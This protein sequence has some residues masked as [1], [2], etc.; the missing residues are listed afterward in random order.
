[1][2][3]SG[4]IVEGKKKRN[5]GTRKKKREGNGFSN[6]QKHFLKKLRS[7][8]LRGLRRP[9]STWP[10]YRKALPDNVSFWRLSKE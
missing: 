5:R 7:S 9:S 6:V 1:M 3:P 4:S 2:N 8:G 10:L